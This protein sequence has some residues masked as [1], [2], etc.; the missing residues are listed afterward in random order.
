MHTYMHRFMSKNEL[1]YSHTHT[2]LCSQVHDAPMLSH[3]CLCRNM[4]TIS[5]YILPCIYT[6]SYM[7]S[8]MHTCSHSY[9]HI[10]I[11]THHTPLCTL[12]TH[13]HV[14]TQDSL[15][16]SMHTFMHMYTHEPMLTFMFTDCAHTCHY[17]VPRAGSCF[18]RFP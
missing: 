13:T 1:T 9:S 5:S 15:V 16:H 14:V 17:R 8:H 11:V 3:A 18:F 7:F 12:H 2:H 4:S 6:T 10:H